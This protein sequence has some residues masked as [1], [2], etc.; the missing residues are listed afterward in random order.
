MFS[1]G[2]KGGG[3][4]WEGEGGRWGEGQLRGAAPGWAFTGEECSSPVEADPPALVLVYSEEEAEG[5]G[6]AGC[7][8]VVVYIGWSVGVHCSTGYGARIVFGRGG[9]DGLGGNG[10]AGEESVDVVECPAEM[11]AACEGSTCVAS[12]ACAV[13]EEE[14]AGYGNADAE[15]DEVGEDEIGEV[16]KCG[17]ADEGE[18]RGWYGVLREEGVDGSDVVDEGMDDC[19]CR[20]RGRCGKGG[21][22]PVAEGEH[23]ENSDGEKEPGKCENGAGAKRGLLLES[24][25]SK[26]TEG[27]PQREKEHRLFPRRV[28]GEDVSDVTDVVDERGEGDEMEDQRRGGCGDKVDEGRHGSK[29]SCTSELP[30]Y[31]HRC[32]IFAV[33]QLSTCTWPAK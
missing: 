16:E 2:D 7:R 31:D 21:V 9:G 14:R 12:P 27:P 11:C 10:R 20:G 32:T 1:D 3:R 13:C 8:G 25:I 6:R 5:R 29:L 4:G 33:D 28:P 26:E 22:G 18:R 23:E 30:I 19:V 15:G 17:D 24:E